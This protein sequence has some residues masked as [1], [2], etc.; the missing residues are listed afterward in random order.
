MTAKLAKKLS[1]RSVVL[2]WNPTHGQS[3]DQLRL[4]NV[5]EAKNV[6]FTSAKLTLGRLTAAAAA[7]QPFDICFVQADVLLDFLTLA[8]NLEVDNG[9]SMSIFGD[10]AGLLFRA[11]DTTYLQVQASVLRIISHQICA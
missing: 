5:M 3:A 10:L 11:C 6:L 2:S 1:P 9:C 7:T 4:M 8:K